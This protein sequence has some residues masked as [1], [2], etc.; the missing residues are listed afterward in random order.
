MNDSTPFL[1]FFRRGEVARD[2]RLLAAQGAL[3]PRASEQLALLLFLLDDRDPG[4]RTTARATI[5]RIPEAPLAAFLA[6]PDVPLGVREFFADRG[7]FPSVI[8]D[9]SFEEPLIDTSPDDLDLGGD[10][11]D[12]EDEARHLTIAQ[13]IA[14]LGLT[15]KLKAALKGCR[16]VRAIL[17]RDPNKMIAV[18]VLSSPRLMESEVEAFARM[19]NV[20]EEVL[21]AIASNRRWMKSYTVVV[22]LARNPKTPV[23]VSLH[24]LP[25][26]SDRDATHVSMDR[27]VPD[28]LRIAARRRVVLGGR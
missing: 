6:R 24:L 4:V 9:L 11:E 21:R 1:D 13:E 18:S 10:D 2:V 3:A 23:G 16:T 8:P 14:K 19:A 20:Q 17:V 5:D 25:R 7:V 12:D 15:D 22:G 27:N 26:L 28:P